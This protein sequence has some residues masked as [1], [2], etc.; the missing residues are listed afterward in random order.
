MKI[1]L[2]WALLSQTDGVIPNWE[3]WALISLWTTVSN[4]G[5][6]LKSERLFLTGSIWV[7]DIP[8]IQISKYL[9]IQE[10]EYPTISV[11][12][13]SISLS[14]YPSSMSSIR[15]S[16]RTASDWRVIL[17]TEHRVPTHRSLRSNQTLLAE[18]EYFHHNNN[19]NINSNIQT[20][21][22]ITIT[23]TLHIQIP[24][25]E[26]EH[27]QPGMTLASNIGKPQ[28]N[29]F[30]IWIMSTFLPPPNGQL[31]DHCVSDKKSISFDT[32]TIDKFFC[33][34]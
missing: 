3:H 30:L 20:I 18:S 9:S 29:D 17:N 31:A 32:Y 8:T 10:L 28:K 34:I 1:H 21:T 13:L 14:E 25:T 26:S 33:Y 16:E 27:F 4:W 15:V 19:E 7:S 11:T 12:N 2:C 22:T 23:I 24:F 6:L 5:V